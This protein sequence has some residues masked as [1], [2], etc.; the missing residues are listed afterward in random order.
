M[1]IMITAQFQGNRGSGI[2]I[3]FSAI[4]A[5]LREKKSGIDQLRM[6]YRVHKIIS[7]IASLAQYVEVDDESEAEKLLLIVDD[8][9]DDV[10]QWIT[11]RGV[12]QSYLMKKI[13]SDLLTIQFIT[14]NK[15]ADKT[16][17]N[18]V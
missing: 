13:L 14:S 11:E 6:L 10:E 8:L 5:Q 2:G 4:L 7:K 15:L 17:E 12:I 16:L 18:R 9:I 1:P 3:D